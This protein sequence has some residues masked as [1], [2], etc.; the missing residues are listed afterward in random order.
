MPLRSSAQTHAAP[1]GCVRQLCLQH[2]GKPVRRQPRN[3]TS[4]GGDARAV[5]HRQ[6]LER[7]GPAVR[8]YDTP[9]G[10]AGHLLVNDHVDLELAGVLL[11]PWQNSKGGTCLL[12]SGERRCPFTGKCRVARTCR[13]MRRLECRIECHSVTMQSTLA[14]C[15]RLV[16]LANAA[17]PDRCAGKFNNCLKAHHRA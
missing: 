4:A 14:S 15:Q 12:P 3:S 7:P 9:G 16:K 1:K 17:R 2:C 6:V 11:S 10:T 5:A 8:L 13:S